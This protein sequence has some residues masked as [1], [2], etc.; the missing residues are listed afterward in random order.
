MRLSEGA[1]LFTLYLGIVVSFITKW[2]NFVQ[3]SLCAFFSENLVM[4][5]SG[6]LIWQWGFNLRSTI[7]P[8][9]HNAD[10]Y[11]RLSSNQNFSTEAR[12]NDVLNLNSF[13]RCPDSTAWPI[14]ELDWKTYNLHLNA[15][16]INVYHIF[17]K[18]LSFEYIDVNFSNMGFWRLK[19]VPS[20]EYIIM[21]KYNNYNI[22]ILAT[23]ILLTCNSLQ[24]KTNV[25]PWKLVKVLL[26]TRVNPL[27]HLRVLNPSPT[28][29]AAASSSPRSHL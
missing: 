25:L 9:H 17:K 14:K 11:M 29:P 10:D 20:D 21:R 24:S 23:F 4:G 8:I 19:S 6:S 12:K 7:G 16:F 27:H 22:P 1:E 15:R 18:P 26:L 5:P 2:G 28:R 3:T 13:E